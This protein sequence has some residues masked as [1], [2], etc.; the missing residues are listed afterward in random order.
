MSEH[1]K[2]LVTGGAG[3]IGSHLVDWLIDDGFEV[4][5][6]DNLFAGK[7]DNIKRHL[8]KKEFKLIKEDMRYPWVVRKALRDVEAVFNEAALVSVD[9]SFEKPLVTEEI[10]V[11]GTINLL[12]ASVKAGVK[13]FIHASSTAVYGEP[14]NL[15]IKETHALRPI[16]PYGASKLSAELYCQVYHE[17]YGLNT[18]VLRY[19]NVYG[20]RQM[21]GPYSGAITNFIGR[22]TEEKP[23]VIYGDGLQTRDF[24]HVDDIVEANIR[25][26]RDEKAVGEVFNIAT[27]K[28]TS[29]NT[30]TN[31][32][33]DLSEK[34]NLRPTYVEPRAGDIR[35]S[36]ADVS[37]ARDVLGFEARINLKDGLSRILQSIE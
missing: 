31:M 5:V 18:I 37:K 25:A 1:F 16:S 13:R 11:L 10:N 3:F 8:R 6:L 30:L 12:Q 4:V 26:L 9:F 15:P 14:T 36:Y 33:L 17:T 32:I 34:K 22:I 24:I 7:M 35:D 23:P 29:I 20:S 27:G 2:V 21:P 19:F 28:P